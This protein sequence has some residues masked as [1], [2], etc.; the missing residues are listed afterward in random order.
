MLVCVSGGG[1]IVE[2]DSGRMP[3][4]VAYLYLLNACSRKGGLQKKGMS[5]RGSF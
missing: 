1:R 5:E 3:N 2:S 4:V